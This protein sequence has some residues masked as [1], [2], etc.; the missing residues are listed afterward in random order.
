M[1]DES[2]EKKTYYY[3]DGIRR[4]IYWAYEQ[5]A[6]LH[7]QLVYLGSSTNPNKRMAIHVFIRQFDIPK[8]WKLKHINE[9]PF[10]RFNNDLED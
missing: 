8:G 3:F 7:N 4:V 10:Y 6:N 2:D 9:H 1:S 5:P